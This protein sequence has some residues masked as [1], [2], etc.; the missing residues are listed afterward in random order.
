[1]FSSILTFNF[2]FLIN[3]HDRLERGLTKVFEITSLNVQNVTRAYV[4]AEEV[5]ERLE[6]LGTLNDDVRN[7][8]S[9]LPNG[10]RLL[11]RK[12]KINKCH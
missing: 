7:L 1:M 3:K 11:P 9:Q 6:E 10:K 2:L 12:K 5:K 4:T 8:V